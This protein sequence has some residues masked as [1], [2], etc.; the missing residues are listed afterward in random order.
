MNCFDCWPVPLGAGKSLA[1]FGMVSWLAWTEWKKGRVSDGRD[2]DRFKKANL[3]ASYSACGPVE[4]VGTQQP[5]EN[6][7]PRAA[8]RRAVRE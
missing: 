7:Q 6:G 5:P 8:R 3:P 1:P 2:L 4:P